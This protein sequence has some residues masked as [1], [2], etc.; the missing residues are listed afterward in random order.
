MEMVVEWQRVR[1]RPELLE[2]Y[3]EADEA[4]WTAGLRREEGFLG[5]EVWLDRE[6][7]GE[8]VLVI[9]WRSERHW[10][11]IPE[12]RLEDLERQFRERMPEGHERIEMR[13][14]EVKG[15]EAGSGA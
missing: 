10:K 3:L 1:V 4:V 8:A 12:E 14:F 11:G 5:K 6:R 9:R 15:G 2:R 13:A 7:S